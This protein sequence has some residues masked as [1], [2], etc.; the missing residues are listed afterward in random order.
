M[1]STK[2]SLLYGLAFVLLLGC[3]QTQMALN[4]KEKSGL[5]GISLGVAYGL[6]SPDIEALPLCLA[7]LP[8]RF[9]KHNFASAWGF[10]VGK[11]AVDKF[12]GYKKRLVHNSTPTF[13]D[14]DIKIL[15]SF[16]GEKVQTVRVPG[17]FNIA[18]NGFNVFSFV[19]IRWF[20]SFLCSP[21]LLEKD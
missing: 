21:D 2:K 16:S 17:S 1:M 15:D 19:C 20:L 6:A 4:A 10:L 7:F 14:I 3:V 8:M 5:L 18:E 13:F 9:G 11:C 12:Y